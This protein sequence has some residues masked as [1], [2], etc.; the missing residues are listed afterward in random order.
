MS[1]VLINGPFGIGKS[2]VAELLAQQMPETVLFDPETI[3]AYLAHTLGREALGDDYQDLPLWRHLFVDFALRLQQDWRPNLV[4]PMNLWRH[5][6]FSEIVAGLGRNGTT[7][8]CFRLTCSPDTLRARILAR[9]DADGGHD[10][11]LSHIESG[12]A[13]ANDPCFGIA[14]D[15]EGQTPQAIADRILNIAGTRHG[16]PTRLTPEAGI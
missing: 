14:I 15:T 10:W 2:T 6:Y 13:A 9:P 7:V 5:D 11:C 3:G 12:L 8:T 4:I 1:I 16:I